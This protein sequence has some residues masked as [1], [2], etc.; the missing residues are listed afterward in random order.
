[1]LSRFIA[2]IIRSSVGDWMLAIFT[3]LAGVVPILISPSTA[4][5]LATRALR[6]APVVKRAGSSTT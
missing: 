6:R 2:E 3:A 4:I 1:M 5:P